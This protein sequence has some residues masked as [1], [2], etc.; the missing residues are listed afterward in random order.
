MRFLRQSLTGLFV[1]SLTLALLVWAGQT[2]YGAVQERMAQEPRVPQVRERVFAV[3]VI[4]AEPA[5]IAPVLSTF[6][7]VQSSRTLDVRAATGGAVIALSD[8]FEEG[9]QVTAGEV[10]IQIDPQN[11]QSALDRVQSD[12]LD[13]RAEGRDADRAVLL[14]RDELAAAQEQV[15]LRERALDRQR[16]LAERGVGSAAA[17]ETAELSASSARQA[18]LS[19]RQA[20]AQAEARVDQAVTRL[21]RAEI[22][23]AEAQRRLE[24]T[25]VR[26][27]FAGTLT[28]VAVVEGGLVSANERLARLVD[29]DRLEATVRL[30]TAQYAR[31]LDDAG[32]LRN[33]PV[34]VTLDVFGVGLTSTGTISRES[35]AVGEGQT[36]RVIFVRLDEVRGLKPGDFVTVAIEEPPLDGVVRLPASAVDAAQTVLAIGAEDRLE[37]IDVT[38]VRRQGDDVLVRGGPALAGRD[39]VAQRTPLLGAGIKVRAIR[40]QAG[41]GTAEQPAMLELSDERRARLV[42]FIEANQTMPAEAKARVLSQLNQPAVPSSV[43]ARIEGRMGG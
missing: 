28:D 31:L 15:A 39:I 5:T 14:A 43:V 34:S 8:A 35:A 6:G 19:R 30:S 13:A 24:D 33:A 38:L 27:Q 37:V 26:A 42:A 18:V 11:A 12:L 41:A 17:V 36:G 10:L 9:G 20:L 1:V 3:N 2:I 32:R 29:P 25:T 21:S 7:E 23:M 16:D 22:A 40:P 4:T